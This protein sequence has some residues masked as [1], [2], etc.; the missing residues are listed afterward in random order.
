MS[1]CAL[2]K[3]SWESTAQS[4]KHKAPCISNE[5]EPLQMRDRSPAGLR[6]QANSRLGQPFLSFAKTHCNPSCCWE[7]C[8]AKLDQQSYCLQDSKIQRVIVISLSI[9]SLQV[10]VWPRWDV[11][12]SQTEVS[13]GQFHCKDARS[14]SA[15]WNSSCQQN[16]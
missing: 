5:A 15:C 1:A 3:S 12:S 2:R 8:V 14:T 16:N 6:A 4:D 13:A 11:D 7:V 10:N 9:C